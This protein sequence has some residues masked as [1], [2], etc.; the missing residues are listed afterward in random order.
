MTIQE[1]ATTHDAAI[2]TDAAGDI[3]LLRRIRDDDGIQQV[4]FAPDPCDHLPQSQWEAM[5]PEEA[6]R[7]VC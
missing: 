2:I 3:A 4:R 1:I 6:A 7:R 5:T